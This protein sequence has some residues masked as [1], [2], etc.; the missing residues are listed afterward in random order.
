MA[1]ETV[2]RADAERNRRQL[3]LAA[4]SVFPEQGYEAPM[5]AIA[6]EAGVGVGT[7]YRRF[8]DRTALLVAVRQESVQTLLAAAQRAAQEEPSA[9][10]AL[11]RI[12]VHSRE[13]RLSMRTRDSLPI[14]TQQALAADEHSTTLRRQLLTVIDHL[15]AAAQQQG[16][17]RP[18][19]G[20]G[21]VARLL[22]LVNIPPRHSGD[23]DDI[24]A[25]RLAAIVLDGLRAGQHPP[26]PGEPIGGSELIPSGG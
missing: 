2:L 15:V 23:S 11:V 10:E 21:D 4:M 24:M 17:M 9:W 19:V 8:P 25:R 5:S 20:G 3:V 7:L 18:D 12:T 26:L 14:E 22:A 13:L 16:S 1:A 6:Q